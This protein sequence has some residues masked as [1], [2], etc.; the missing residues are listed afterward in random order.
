[1]GCTSRTVQVTGRTGSVGFHVRQ[2][3]ALPCHP[4]PATAGPPN[5]GPPPGQRLGGWMRIGSRGQD[6]NHRLILASLG[7]SISWEPKLSR[8][9]SRLTIGAQARSHGIEQTWRRHRTWA[10][11][12]ACTWPNWARWRLGGRRAWDVVRCRGG[13]CGKRAR[14]LPWA[15]ADGWA[16]E[17]RM[18]TPFVLRRRGRLP[19]YPLFL[20]R[21]APWI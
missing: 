6:E 18:P 21:R 4:P 15:P 1:M 19:S 13:A 7:S 9:G 5:P 8:C 3:P 14:G 20:R 2:R 12:C 17:L 16:S 11:R 10:A